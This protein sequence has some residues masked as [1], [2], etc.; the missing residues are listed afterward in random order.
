MD[1]GP[2]VVSVPASDSTSGQGG[3]SSSMDS[4]TRSL[5]CLVLVDEETG[6]PRRVATEMEAELVA[7]SL[8]KDASNSSL[9]CL[10]AVSESVSASSESDSETPRYVGHL[11]KHG[12]PCQHCGTSASPQ[13]RRGPPAKPVLC[14]ACGTRFRRTNQLSPLLATAAAALRGS[15]VLP[16]KRCNNA[17]NNGMERGRKEARLMVTVQ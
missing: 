12:G 17:R 10:R 7:R 1:K 11:A 14:N 9:P 2:L 6:Q 5:Y 8:H 4:G 13:W 3:F 16:R 15:P